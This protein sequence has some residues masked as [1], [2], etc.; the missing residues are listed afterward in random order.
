MNP[1][2]VLAFVADA[3]HQYLADKFQLSCFATADEARGA[4]FQFA[5]TLASDGLKLEALA[6]N[7]L[8]PLE[9]DFLSSALR[10][11]QRRGGESELLVKAI[12]IRPSLSPTVW[13]LTAGMGV[14]AWILASLGYRVRAFERHP[15]VFA[16]L[17][18]AWRRL[19]RQALDPTMTAAVERL[20]FEQRDSHSLAQSGDIERPD[21]VYLDPMFPAKQHHAKAKKAMQ[22]LQAIVGWE[23]DSTSLLQVAKQWAEYR[24]VV[25]RAPKAPPLD[26]SPVTTAINGKNVRYDIYAIKSVNHYSNKKIAALDSQ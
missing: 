7:D 13:D 26:D 24:V 19:G 5:L 2:P 3:N 16:L 10:Y 18:D 20:R 8:G 1:D 23:E 14:D 11:R 17:E 21:I 22:Y 15:I 4:G 12:G 9:I 25:K 6:Q